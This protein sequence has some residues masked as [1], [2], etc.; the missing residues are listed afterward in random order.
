MRRKY[1]ATLVDCRVVSCRRVCSLWQSRECVG[2]A[3]GGP[4]PLAI[5]VL[6]LR[7]GSHESG[8]GPRGCVA[9]WCL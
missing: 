4:R 8:L 2:N 1:A 3:S 9:R 7:S 5:Y 6:V